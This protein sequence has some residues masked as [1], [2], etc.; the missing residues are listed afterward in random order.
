M[1]VLVDMD[2]VLELLVDAVVKHVNDI[3]GTHARAEDVKEWDLSKAFATLTH[4]QVYATVDDA[5]LWDLVQPMP[6]AA[7]ALQKIMADGD[8]LYIVTASELGNLKKK[9]QDVLFKYYPFLD[10]FQVIITHKKQLICGDVLVD[11]GPHN[12]TGGP[13]RKILFDAGHNRSFDEKSVGAV[14]VHSWEECYRELCRIRRE[15]EEK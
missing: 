3:Y 6:G 7:E 2:D 5:E 14:R 11:D 1:I 12:L 8:E 9:M 13:Y 15:I 4:E 10:W